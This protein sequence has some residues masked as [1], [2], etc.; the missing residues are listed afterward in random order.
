VPTFKAILNEIAARIYLFTITPGFSREEEEIVSKTVDAFST[1]MEYIPSGPEGFDRFVGWPL[2]VVESISLPG[3]SF[4]RMFVER[5][6]RLGELSSIGTFR[7]A[8]WKICIRD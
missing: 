5:A 3:S 7:M 1:A 8:S 4:R 2:L 6:R